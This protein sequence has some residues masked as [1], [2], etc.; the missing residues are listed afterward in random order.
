MADKKPVLPISPNF[1]K[2]E[3]GFGSEMYTRK[4]SG[5]DKEDVKP[6]QPFRPGQYEYYHKRGGKVGGGGL[7]RGHYVKNYC[8]GGKV[9]SSSK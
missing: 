9:I 7:N 1:D 2:R 8:A 5:L 4:A 3:F 6:L